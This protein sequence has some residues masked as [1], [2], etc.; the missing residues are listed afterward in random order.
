MKHQIVLGSLLTAESRR[1]SIRRLVDA[2]WGTAPPS[3]A[4]KQIR[5]AVSD[6]RGILA[7]SG[8]LITPAADGYQLDIGEAWFDLREFHRHLGRARTLL[9]HQRSA[10]VIAEFRAALSLWTGP[11]L[12][13][14]ESAALQAQVAGVNEV[15]LSAAEECIDLELT[16]DRHKSL[17]SELSALVA[18]NPLRERMVAQYV[19]ALYRSGTRARA[20]AVYEQTRR[21]LAEQLGLSPGP[22]LV[23]IHQL[24]LREDAGAAGPT[25][26][27]PPVPAAT[28]APVAAA[29]DSLPSEIGHFVGRAAEIEV[30]LADGT[31]P[32]PQRVVSV[33]G[34]GGAGKTALAVHVAHRL[35][36]RYPDGRLFLDLRGRTCDR[37]PLGHRAAL[38]RLLL[39]SG[40]PE[41]ELPVPVEALVQLWRS[42]TVGRRML[43]VLD[44]AADAE[45]IGPLLP[46]GDGCLTLVTSRRRLTM[47]TLSPTRVLSLEPLPRKEGYE[48][49]CRL[50]GNRHPKP[51]PDAVNG[52]L[53]HCGDLPLAVSAAAARLRRRPSWPVWHLAERL[54]D[55]QMRL[56]E[57]QTE[58]GGL[59][60]CFDASYRHLSAGQQRLLRLLGAAEGDRTDV[61]SASVLAGLPPFVAEQMLEELVDEHLLMQPEPGRYR[62]HP[63][64]KTYCAQLPA[65]DGT[66]GPRSAP[67][68]VPAQT[69]AA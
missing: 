68:R 38:R 7:P 2:V 18:E 51:L 31:R 54:A 17:L 1:T 27:G 44:N 37:A 49:F 63:L 60:A 28:S 46:A 55:R 57:L 62:M 30:L 48:L 22:E 39:L 47:T 14:I 65:P 19:R 50:L 25:A 67:R 16:R 8:A 13:G 36:D 20:F 64:M 56:A 43:V 11:M 4:G 66:T 24:M 26:A 32:G 23:E 15:R 69:M 42:R 10:D 53:E 45:Q 58:H 40:L 9:G 52:I 59:I 41:A 34:M 61:G 6:L 29:P 33:D 3:T 35:A 5:N 21:R 12:S